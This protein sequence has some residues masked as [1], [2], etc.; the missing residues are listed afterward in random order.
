[1]KTNFDFIV[2]KCSELIKFE[3]YERVCNYVVD[4]VELNDYISSYYYASLLQSL[5]SKK[6]NACIYYAIHSKVLTLLSEKTNVQSAVK[7]SRFLG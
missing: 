5:H 7:W 1:M 3:E 4:S 6:L 2:R